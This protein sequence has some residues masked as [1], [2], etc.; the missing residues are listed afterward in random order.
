MGEWMDGWVGGWTGGWFKGCLP[1]SIK[2]QCFEGSN[3]LLWVGKPYISLQWHIIYCFKCALFAQASTDWKC[4]LIRLGV[5]GLTTR[6]QS[7]SNFNNL[8]IILEIVK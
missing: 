8:Q 4:C 3:F 5:C 7:K 2:F 6:S 1:Q